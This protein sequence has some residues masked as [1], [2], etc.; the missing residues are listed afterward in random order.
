MAIGI[1]GTIFFFALLLASGLR[2]L[3]EYE[4]GVIFRFG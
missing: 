2:V 4:R 1:L 3:K